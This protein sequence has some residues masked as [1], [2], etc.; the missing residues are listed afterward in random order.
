LQPEE[1]AA[2]CSAEGYD[3]SGPDLAAA[4]ALLDADGDGTVQFPDFAA[5]RVKKLAVPSGGEAGV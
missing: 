5:W 1:L 2:L 3:L 4:T